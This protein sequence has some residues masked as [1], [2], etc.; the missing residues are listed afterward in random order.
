MHG[1][2]I[3]GTGSYLPA[4]V[5]VAD[6]VADGRYDAA[7]A[8]LFG[9]QNALVAGAE[10]APEMAVE[11]GR[12]ALTRSG[13]DPQEIAATF[14]ASLYHQGPDVWPVHMYLQREI[15][16]LEVSAYEVRQGCNGGMA[17]MELASYYLNASPDRTAAVL[18]TADNFG[19]LGF[20]RW[21][22][23][24]GVIFSDGGTA[25]VLSKEPGLGEVRSIA[26]T[27]IQSLE[28]MLR[29]EM[30]HPFAYTG[31]KLVN[32][33]ARR[34]D[35]QSRSEV[36]TLWFCDAMLSEAVPAVVKQALADADIDIADVTRVIWPNL[37]SV[38]V[39][40]YCEQAGLDPA[41]STWEWGRTIGHLGAGDQFAGLDH[42][43][44]GGEVGPGDHVLVMGIGVGLTITSAVVTIC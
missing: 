42:L 1:I 14:H 34:L 15:V 11:A 22:A 44:S 25:L 27:S 41:L 7:D 36:D 32:F 35:F 33:T 29:G 30:P 13:H 10:S 39:N 19:G 40:R 2:F 8:E 31:E 9:I 3:A 16:G 23:E 12:L 4:K 17:A 28:E 6:A 26:T 24:Q 21:R 38:I 43:I 37:G 5:P 20:N 18:T